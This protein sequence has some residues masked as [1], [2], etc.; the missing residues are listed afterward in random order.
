M[1]QTKC[2]YK[3]IKVH[4]IFSFPRGLWFRFRV[5]FDKFND[6]KQSYIMLTSFYKYNIDP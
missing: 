1:P 3:I 2:F 4:R 5:I 6:G